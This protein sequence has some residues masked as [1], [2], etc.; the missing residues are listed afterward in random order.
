MIE[1]EKIQRS[2]LAAEFLDSRFWKDYLEPWIEKQKRRL[3]QENMA[4]PNTEKFHQ[5]RE[6]MK[7]RWTACGMIEQILN[8][9]RRDREFIEKSNKLEKARQKMSGPARSK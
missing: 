5:K 2:N 9:W 6:E 3:E 4:L 7:S 8:E 1:K